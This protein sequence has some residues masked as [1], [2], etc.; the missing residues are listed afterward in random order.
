MIREEYLHEMKQLQTISGFLKDQERRTR[1]QQLI[2]SFID[3]SFALH[4]KM[5][6]EYLE[7]EV[8]DVE[9]H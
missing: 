8:T 7:K 2:N 6:R 4:D 1:T 3:R 9:L 5:S